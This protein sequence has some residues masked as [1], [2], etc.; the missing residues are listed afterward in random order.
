MFSSSVLFYH[1]EKGSFDLDD[2]VNLLHVSDTHTY[3]M[4]R[5][6]ELPLKEQIN[7]HTTASA[8]FPCTYDDN[9]VGSMIESYLSI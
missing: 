8:P 3:L 7:F 6:T 9:Y 1:S 2:E 5:M 4:N